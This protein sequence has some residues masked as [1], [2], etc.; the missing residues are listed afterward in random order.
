[1]KP[2]GVVIIGVEVVGVSEWWLG[3]S[4]INVNKNK[5]FLNAK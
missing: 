1:M 3:D 4:S 2:A 5:F